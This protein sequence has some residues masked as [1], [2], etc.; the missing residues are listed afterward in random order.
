MQQTVMSIIHPS[1]KGK[2]SKWESEDCFCPQTMMFSDSF[3]LY[4]SV[5]ITIFD[6]SPM[7]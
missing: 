1:E 5:T 3:I 6:L 7:H 4:A 2:L